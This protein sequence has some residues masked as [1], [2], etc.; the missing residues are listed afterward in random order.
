MF[1]LLYKEF[2]L[3]AHPTVFIF[4]AF[5]FMM[6]IPSYPYYVAFIY[7]CLA[8]FFVFMSGRE[9]KDV[10]YTVSLPIKKSDAVKARCMMIAIIELAQMIISVPFAMLGTNINPN[11]DGNQ[12]GIEANVAFFG[13]VFIMFALFNL[14]FIPGFY[15]TGYKIGGPFLAAG[16]AV[17][18][19]IVVA[20]SLVWIPT[21]LKGFLDTTAPDIMV[22]QL[23]ILAAGII[24]WAVS[25]VA[26]Y[27]AGAARFEKVD[28]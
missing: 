8:I 5:A 23:P 21:P 10:F 19:Y 13:L 17:L 4:L 18:L 22:K 12:A 6:L 28:L 26:S 24:I 9:N 3:A 15:K 20:E 16:T 25:V 14:I 2:K 1:N 7:T 27:K 11:A